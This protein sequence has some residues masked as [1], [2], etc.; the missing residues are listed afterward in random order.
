MHGAIVYE[1]SNAHNQTNTR[2]NVDWQ[3]KIKK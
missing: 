2:Q 1:D 3:Y